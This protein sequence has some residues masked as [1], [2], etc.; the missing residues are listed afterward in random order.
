MRP[1]GR[2]RNVDCNVVLDGSRG[3][4]GGN[5]GRG[6][7]RDGGQG[8]KRRVLWSAQK[9]SVITHSALHQYLCW[10]PA[11]FSLYSNLFHGV[12]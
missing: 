7:E 9:D 4:R 11:G 12:V 2:H 1:D 6:E 3:Q 5:G 8:E 10:D